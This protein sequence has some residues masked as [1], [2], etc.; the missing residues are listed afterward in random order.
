MSVP[1]PTPF[2][3]V[4]DNP[5]KTVVLFEAWVE[6]IG[7]YFLLARRRNAQ[8]ERR[9]RM[10]QLYTPKMLAHLKCATFFIA[11][12]HSLCHNP[13]KFNWTTNKRGITLSF[14]DRVT[15]WLLPLFEHDC[16]AIISIFSFHNAIKLLNLKKYISR[17]AA[18]SASTAVA[19]YMNTVLGPLANP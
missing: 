14:A 15:Q 13:Q 2:K 7:H 17:E 18:I 12:D 10:S 3:P 6:A 8:G 4:W 5:E 9:I 16:V 1:T 11:I 19:E